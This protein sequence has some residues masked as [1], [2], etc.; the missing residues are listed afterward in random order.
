MRENRMFQL[1]LSTIVAATLKMD[2][3]QECEQEECADRQTDEKTDRR[4]DG[5]TD[6]RTEAGADTEKSERGG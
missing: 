2:T 5:R 4:T 1:V 3:L 6:G